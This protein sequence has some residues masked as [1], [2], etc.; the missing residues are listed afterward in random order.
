[1]Y[2]TKKLTIQVNVNITVSLKM[3]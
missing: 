2:K 3:V 1:M